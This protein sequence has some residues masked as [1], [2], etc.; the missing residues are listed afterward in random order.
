MSACILFQV[1]MEASH[2][3]GELSCPRDSFDICLLGSGHVER[4]LLLT[5]SV[6]SAL[7]VLGA[8]YRIQQG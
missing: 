2:T 3:K 5:K 1:G 7:V 4:G 6:G 8:L